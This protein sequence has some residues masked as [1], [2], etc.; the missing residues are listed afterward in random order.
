MQC[1]Y[2]KISYKIDKRIKNDKDNWIIVKGTHEALVSY[3]DFDKIQNLLDK[4]GFKCNN[5]GTLSIFAGMIK[6]GDCKNSMVRNKS[7][8]KKKDGSDIVNYYCSTYIRKSHELCT[9]HL[10]KAEIV[11]DIVL[12]AVQN[13]IKLVLNQEKL[14][15]DIYKERN[16][17]H[18]KEEYQEKINSIN[19]NIKK[20]EN[21]KKESYLDWKKDIITQEDY[22]MFVEDYSKKIN[23]YNKEIAELENKINNIKDESI[24]DYFRHYRKYKNIDKLDRTI[25]TELVETIYIYEDKKIEINFKYNDIYSKINDYIREEDL[26]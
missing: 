9:R 5:N 7:G 19:E 16:Q 17:N 8:N 6:C 12:K 21:I 26:N 22:F 11:E 15:N 18:I 3:K 14:I 4:R 13:Q 25:T 24:E 10:I 20:L 23:D 2:K 1:K